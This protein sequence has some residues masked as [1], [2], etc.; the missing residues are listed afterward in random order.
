MIGVTQLTACAYR[1]LLIEIDQRPRD[2]RQVPK[3]EGVRFG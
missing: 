3:R 1:A 2:G